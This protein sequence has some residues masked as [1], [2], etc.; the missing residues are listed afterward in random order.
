MKIV[1]ITPWFSEN[2]GYSE[3]FLP[4][5][6]A[7]LDQEVH[8]ITSTAQIY[9]NDVIYKQVYE[10]FLGPPVLPPTVKTMNGFMLHRLPLINLGNKLP[11]IIGLIDYLIELKPDVVQ[12][13][14]LEANT[15]FE[16]AI[17][18]DKEKIK[19]YTEC[20]LHASI[21]KQFNRFYFINYI[22]TFLK[23]FNY[24]IRYV[25]K[26]MELCYPI[27]K[28]VEDIVI[29]HFGVNQ[30]KVKIQSLGV[31]LELFQRPKDDLY[32]KKRNQYRNKL[33]FDDS[34]IVCIYTGRLTKSKN[35][36]CLA[37]A[38]NYLNDLNKPFKGLFV[39]NGTDA[40]N[41]KI[42][43]NKG[44]IINPFVIVDNLPPFYWASD[45][46]VWPRQESTSQLDAMSAELPLILSDK[47]ETKERIENNG[48]LYLEDDFENLAKKLLSLEN[49]SFRSDLG[50]NG[51]NKIKKLYS[52]DSLAKNRI[53]DYNA[54]QKNN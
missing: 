17:F 1:L 7:K 10:E 26:V 41:E 47:I 48:L 11:G 42:I 21:F 36:L 30:D 52:W 29:S 31:D 28:D 9:Y 20:H 22:K 24:K 40:Y 19:L 12:T 14:D 34:D 53:K 49:K 15:T 51:F 46:G 16:A 2:M 38:I 50:K 54:I 35:P 8:V 37:K 6:L 43:Q 25:I 3:N 18:C 27:A 33:G 45:I 5:A 32:L 44:C 39:G 4:K 13:F 23:K